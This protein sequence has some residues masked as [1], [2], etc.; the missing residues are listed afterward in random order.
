MG[1][2]DYFRS[3]WKKPET[4]RVLV[5]GCDTG[6]GRALVGELCKKNV[7]VFSGCLTEKAVDEL[8]KEYNTVFPF[9][10]DI[11]SDESVANAVEFVAQ[12]PQGKCIDVVVNNAGIGG[13][14]LV[15][16][17]TMDDFKKCIEVNFF[18]LIRMTKAFMPMIKSS[19]GRFV[20]MTS[21]NGIAPARDITAYTAS[22]HA[23]SAFTESLH[24]EMKHWKV[25]VIEVCPGWM[26]TPIMNVEDRIEQNWEDHPTAIKNEYGMSFPGQLKQLAA[27]GNKIAENPNKVT[28]AYMKAIMSKSPSSRYVVGNL[29]NQMVLGDKFLPR[30]IFWMT[31]KMYF[32]EVLPEGSAAYK[33]DKC[34]NKKSKKNETV[35]TPWGGNDENR[36]GPRAPCSCT[37]SRQLK[38]ASKK[39]EKQDSIKKSHS[40]EFIEVKQENIE[41]EWKKDSNTVYVNE[42]KQIYINGEKQ[43]VYV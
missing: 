19:K 27:A 7:K 25:K 34:K 38:E 4:M 3:N 18:G 9:V 40:I 14:F 21:I 33:S 16:Y 24:Q 12:H 23:A 37:W 20:N 11:T 29:A 17:N 22:K 5:T 28:K 10:L 41:N 39:V 13:G 42:E 6:F 26:K 36:L 8:T 15:D 32:P 30:P 31:S 2:Y 35:A 43:V 1:Y